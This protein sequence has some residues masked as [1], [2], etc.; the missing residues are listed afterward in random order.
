M[1][2]YSLL[3]VLVCLI[4]S[5]AWLPPCMGHEEE[6]QEQEQHAHVDIQADGSLSGVHTEP[7]PSSA[8]IRKRSSG[9]THHHHHHHHHGGG[10][11]HQETLDQH[12]LTAILLTLFSG[13][14]A[15]LGG[16]CVVTFGIPSPSVLGHMLS[17]ASGIMMYIS[18]GDLLK[19]S[20]ADIGPLQANLAMF[21]GML[22]FWVVVTFVPEPELEEL[23]TQE[24]QNDIDANGGQ[25]DQVLQEEE[26]G[27]LSAPTQIQYQKMNVIQ[28]QQ[29][30]RERE[31]P[32]SGRK[33]EIIDRLQAK[34]T[35]ASTKRTRSQSGSTTIRNG[36][37]T[38][39]G[40]V[41][42]FNAN[43]NSKAKADRKRLYMTGLIAALGISLHNF[44]EGLI[45]YSQTITG[46]CDKSVDSFSDI[47]SGQVSLAELLEVLA[48]CTGRG[49]AITFAI[50]LHN[51][52]E[53]MAVASPI[54]ASSGSKWTALKWCILS[55][56]CEPAAA[57]L[58]V[59]FTHYLTP[60]IIAVLNAMVAGIMIMLCIVELIP[61]SIAHLSSRA[62]AL[63]NVVGMFVMYLSIEFMVRNDLH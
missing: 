24:K 60:P 14:A 46:I 13:L 20:E 41:Q 63:S 8:P 32:T 1:K 11:G 38:T 34:G 25:V 29:L 6:E 7:L 50:A 40:N 26:E 35:T 17:F 9:C 45:V 22:F 51:I 39:S 37:A 12:P 48:S 53:G 49:L 62:A 23:A 3:L 43:A 15:T 33:Q 56:L 52:P 16:I 4:I 10:H 47:V 55:S 58:L 31:L 28:L 61:A 36:G 27:V 44:P 42:N 30:C 19:H 2:S 57:F 59:P 18:F 21:G 54:Y 5:S